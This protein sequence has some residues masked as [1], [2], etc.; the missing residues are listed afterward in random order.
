MIDEICDAPWD[1]EA[2]RRCWV[3]AAADRSG[4]CPRSLTSLV[5]AGALAEA[6]AR[7]TA[8]L[9][10][11]LDAGPFEGRANCS[12]IWP[13]QRKFALDDLHP[14]DSCYSNLGGRCQVK[15]RPPKQRARC[16]QL[17]TRQSALD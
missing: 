9:V 11:E 2:D 12:L 16:P 10:D 15:S 3:G 13:R 7:A 5:S 1:W 8:V 4:K 6:H 17:S 14:T